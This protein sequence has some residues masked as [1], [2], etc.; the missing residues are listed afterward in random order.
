MSAETIAYVRDWVII[1]WGAM[2]TMAALAILI[3]TILVY[4]KVSYIL[5]SMRAVV[6]GARELNQRT[7]EQFSALAPLLRIFSRRKKVERD[8]GG[9]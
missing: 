1:I 7:A 3:V 5:N 4:Q 8:E 6:D 9:P 2:A